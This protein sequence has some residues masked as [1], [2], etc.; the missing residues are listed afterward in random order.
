MVQLFTDNFTGPGFQ[1]F[2]TAHLY[3]LLG[4]LL[5]NIFMVMLLKKINSEKINNIIRYFI[6]IALVLQEASLSIWRMYHGRWEIAT[7]LPFHL[8]GLG[9]LFSAYML[10]T[11]SKKLYEFLYFW[12]MAGATQALLQPNLSEFSFPHYR[13]F[14]F[15]VSHGL[16]FAAII[17]ATFILKFRPRFKSIYRAFVITNIFAIFIGVFNFAT[18]AN[19]MFIAHKPDTPSILDFMGPWPLY[20]IPLEF[21]A[22]FLF[23]LVYVPFLVRDFLRKPLSVETKN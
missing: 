2:S 5:F 21:I 14:Q 18:D 1:I 19:Y 3:G 8:C 20:L 12:G 13:Y 9:I 10:M 15:F 11:K 6:A 23:T 22:L 17:F 7:S 4:V 16:F